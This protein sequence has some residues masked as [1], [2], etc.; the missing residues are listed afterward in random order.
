MSYFWKANK[1]IHTFQVYDLIY[2]NLLSVQNI[3]IQTQP[4]EILHNCG[5]LLI[6]APSVRFCGTIQNQPDI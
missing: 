5:L 2:I 4:W 1:Y 3:H 6:N